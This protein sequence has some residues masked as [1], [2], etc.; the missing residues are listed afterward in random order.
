MTG[1][2]IALR[3]LS[4]CIYRGYL[5]NRMTGFFYPPSGEYFRP[6]V[7]GRNYAPQMEGGLYGTQAGQA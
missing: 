4:Y 3:S 7:T 2:L 1:L 5:N 6:V